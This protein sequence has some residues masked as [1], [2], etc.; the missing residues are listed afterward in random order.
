MISLQFENGVPVAINGEAMDP[1]ALLTKLNEIGG[2][3][4]IGIIDILE[5]RV[6]GMK[7]RGIYETPGGTIMFA[8]H[9]QLSHLVWDKETFAHTQKIAVDFAV[10]S[11]PANGSLRC[12]RLFPHTLIL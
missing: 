6:V 3:N 11:T 4:G 7:S 12:A 10:W 5:N 8:A 1:V 9:E 2:A